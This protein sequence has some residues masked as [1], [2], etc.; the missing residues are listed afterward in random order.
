MKAADAVAVALVATGGPI[1]TL[2]SGK[3]DRL[4]G[5]GCE[6]VPPYITGDA[7]SVANC[8]AAVD[9]AQ[10]K[11]GA[12][13]LKHTVTTGGVVGEARLC[14]SVAIDDL[15]ELKAGED[16]TLSGW[17]YVPSVGGP[18]VAESLIALDYYNAGAWVEKAVAAVGQDAF[19]KVTTGRI[20]IPRGAVAAKGLVRIGATASD[21]EYNYWDVI[22]LFQHDQNK[23]T[24]SDRA[25]LTELATD[26][27]AGATKRG[28]DLQLLEILNKVFIQKRLLYHNIFISA[29]CVADGVIDKMELDMDKLTPKARAKLAEIQTHVAAGSFT[30]KEA[31]ELLF[32]IQSWFIKIKY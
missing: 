2:I 7:A 28:R 10:H 23:M 17:V 24:G 22:E 20:T 32:I 25:F 6:T 13:S 9:A 26:L 21:G 29:L 8:S 19:E 3:L 4:T 18:T 15:H 12:K 30:P 14:D 1:A 5:G 31:N 16:Y 27:G 11:V